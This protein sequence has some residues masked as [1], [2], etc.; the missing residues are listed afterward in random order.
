MDSPR[1]ISFSLSTSSGILLA[2]DGGDNRLAVSVPVAAGADVD[3]LAHMHDPVFHCRCPR[4]WSS[5]P[6][7]TARSAPC[8]PA[9]H[10]APAPM[11]RCRPAAQNTAV[12]VPSKSAYT[13]VVRIAK[14]ASPEASTS[15]GEAVKSPTTPEY[16]ARMVFSTAASITPFQLDFGNALLG[17]RCTQHH[18][19]R[20]KQRHHRFFH[21][22]LLVCGGG[23][24]PHPPSSPVAWSPVHMLRSA[25]MGFRLLALRAGA[26]PNMMPTAAEKLTPSPMANVLSEN[27]NVRIHTDR[28]GDRQ[29]H[30]HADHTAQQRENDRLDQK[31][32]LNLPRL[33]AKRFAQGRSPW[34]ARSRS[35]ASCS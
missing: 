22:F 30:D 25:S 10:S 20:R 16:G 14:S 32:H 17:N 6:P 29:P 7:C 27:R 35:P 1:R 2:A 18:P 9:P 28:I 13:G 21:L 34:C 8:K 5:N 3:P 4:P 19:K 11:L 15:P 31:L 33:C 12:T 23:N 26:Q 24:V